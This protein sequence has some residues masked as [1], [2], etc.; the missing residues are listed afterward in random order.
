MKRKSHTLSRYRR[1]EVLTIF[2]TTGKYH[3]GK[4][5]HMLYYCTVWCLPDIW[6]QRRRNSLLTDV[7]SGGQPKDNWSKDDGA[8][9]QMKLACSARTMPILVRARDNIELYSSTICIEA[10][11]QY[12]R[13]LRKALL[14][15]N[16][17][18]IDYRKQI[19]PRNRRKPY[20]VRGTKYVLLYWT[21]F[22]SCFLCVR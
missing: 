7:K 9:S 20:H 16:I 10:V 4:E 18:V 19:T 11:C 22:N 14:L 2:A 6:R 21:I 1:A 15:Q 3:K 12:L 13:V 17:A 5:R 8:S